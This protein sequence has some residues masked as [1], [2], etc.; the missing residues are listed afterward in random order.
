MHGSHLPRRRTQQRAG[1]QE[2]HPPTHAYARSKTSS[3]S[4]DHGSF[5]ISGFKWLMYLGEASRHQAS[6]TH[7][8]IKTTKTMH[9]ALFAKRNGKG[10]R[11][12][13]Y[14]SRHCFPFRPDMSCAMR[15]QCLE[16]ILPTSS[17]SF[18]SSSGFHGPLTTLGLR[19]RCHRWRHCVGDLPG[20]LAA[21][22]FQFLPPFA[23]TAFLRTSS[24]AGDEGMGVRG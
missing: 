4:R 5:R 1:G 23:A 12:G 16:P 19:T 14:R 22:C 15:L 18:A 6:Q 13:A 20:T 8:L 7:R 24:C 21:I 17:L 10:G 11:G 9:R 2:G 3:S